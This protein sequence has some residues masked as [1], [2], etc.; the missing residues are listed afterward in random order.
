M[1][2]DHSIFF[3]AFALCTKAMTIVQEVIGNKCESGHDF[4]YSTVDADSC[5]KCGK[6]LSIQLKNVEKQESFSSDMKMTD[7]MHERMQVIDIDGMHVLFLSNE[8]DDTKIPV[9]T[10]DHVNK[11]IETGDVM[12]MR[13]SFMVSFKKEIDMLRMHYKD[14]TIKTGIVV[15][16]S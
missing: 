7:M 6:S 4:R 15:E 2:L 10:D 1:T 14:V 3:G 9:D 16:W 12:T 11:F 5:P 8:G 13:K